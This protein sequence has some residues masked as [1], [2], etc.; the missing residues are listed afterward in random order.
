MWRRSSKVS[1]EHTSSPRIHQAGPRVPKKTKEEKDLGLACLKNNS[2]QELKRKEKKTQP[3][4]AGRKQ[5]RNSPHT[6]EHK[7]LGQQGCVS[8]PQERCRAAPTTRTNSRRRRVRGNPNSMK[9]KR[10]EKRGWPATTRFWKKNNRIWNNSENSVKNETMTQESD[11]LKPKK[12]H[13]C[14]K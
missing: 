5:N 8:S 7:L 13:R 6:T 11:G 9:P 14:K 3:Q 12:A 10:S 2:Q 4:G 1:G